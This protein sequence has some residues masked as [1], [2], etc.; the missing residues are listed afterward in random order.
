MV[1]DFLLEN[2]FT[3]DFNSVTIK[4]IN[5]LGQNVSLFIPQFLV[6][7]NLNE[8]QSTFKGLVYKPSISKARKREQNK[9]K[10]ISYQM[11]VIARMENSKATVM[12]KVFPRVNLDKII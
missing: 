11:K 9:R 3:I 8:L 12:Q 10:G 4:N 6:D 5:E 7:E 1:G 2:L